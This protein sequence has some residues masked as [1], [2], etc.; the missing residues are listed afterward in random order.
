MEKDDSVK[1]VVL[2]SGKPNSFVAGADINMIKKCKSAEEVE[3]LSRL[4]NDTVHQRSSVTVG[5]LERTTTHR[6]GGVWD[7][8]KRAKGQERRRY[9]TL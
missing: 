4:V 3:K 9:F 2:M 8:E 6:A 7:N 5:N 1:A